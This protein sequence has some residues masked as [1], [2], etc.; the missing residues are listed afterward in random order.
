MPEETK[1]LDANGDSGTIAPLLD[2]N[3]KQDESNT[4]TQTKIKIVRRKQK[5]ANDVVASDDAKS[6]TTLSTK[7]P[8]VPETN[9]EDTII[10]DKDDTEEP[11]RGKQGKRID[12]MYMTNRKRF[13]QKMSELFKQYKE[14]HHD[15]KT[16]ISC[17]P[18]E[19]DGLFAHQELILEY[20]SSNT[21]YRGLLLYH[22]LGSGKTCASIAVAESMKHD[23]SNIIV[24]TPASLS[25]NYLAEIKKCGDPLYKKLQY[26]RFEKTTT[27]EG[28]NHLAKLLSIPVAD[29]TKQGGAW[30]AE[31][32]TRKSNFAD[33][34]VT[35]QKQI[36]QQLDKMIKS[37]Y[38]IYHY[39]GDSIREYNKLTQHGKHNP[40]NNAV[41]IIDEAH[42]FVRR[43]VNKLINKSTK[44]GTKV[45]TISTNLYEL[46]LDA[47]NVRI[48]LLSGTPI[49][50]YPHESGVLFNII[51]GHTKQWVFTLNCEYFT[52][53]DIKVD[54]DFFLDLFVKNNLKTFDYVSYSGNIL[55]V[56]K[57]PYGFVNKY[58][59]QYTKKDGPNANEPREEG[60]K[61]IIKVKATRKQTDKGKK[62][63]KRTTKKQGGSNEFKRYQGVVYDDSGEMSNADFEK[64]IRAIFDRNHIRILHTN[65]T[66]EKCLPDDM[67]EFNQKFL[68]EGQ[69]EI[70]NKAIFQKRILG[71]TSYFRSAQEELLPS[72]ELSENGLH[73]HIVNCDMSP[74]QFAE[75][76]KIREQEFQNETNRKKV[77][78]LKSKQDEVFNIPSSYRTFSRAACNFI[79]PSE[80]KRPY[81]EN[82]RNFKLEDE[83]EGS[84]EDEEET[85]EETKTEKVA[86]TQTYQERIAEALQKL[87]DGEYLSRERIGDFSPKFANI[88]D[89]LSNSE[90]VGLHLVYSNYR[91]IEGIEILRLALLKNGFAQFK[92]QKPRGA[93]TW[94]IV[95]KA[96][97]RMKPKFVLYT[98]TESEE[99]REIIRNIYNSSWDVIP[100]SLQTELTTRYGD[101]KNKLGKVIKA[102]MIT[103]SGAEGINLKNT[104][105]VHL[106]EPYWHMERIEQVIGR[107]RRICSHQDLAPELRT[108]K[109]FFYLSAF[110]DKQQTDDKYKQI[111]L[112]DISRYDQVTPV[113]T[114]QT[115]FEL[116][117]FKQTINGKI[118]DL[119]KSTSID[120]QVYSKGTESYICYSAGKVSATNPN[121]FIS[122]PDL[123]QEEGDEM[124]KEEVKR[125]VYNVKYQGKE[126]L[127]NA[128]RTELYDID[129]YRSTNLLTK[130]GR[131]VKE[132]GDYKIYL[133]T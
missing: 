10:E 60:V 103:A 131:I 15:D 129:I 53:K 100:S 128:E 81:P 52:E 40:F 50:N 47:V 42:N 68:D 88:L 20:L 117:K 94:Q 33:L 121:N 101:E 127:T 55:T 39:N 124:Q 27:Q 111:R 3:E 38:L 78:A 58:T 66:N 89:N 86:E 77:K 56:T 34:T 106:V 11:L 102:L 120:C 62:G 114:D 29:V 123:D 67:E 82:E 76:D 26:W 22:G 79:F 2:I 83:A 113:T 132:N 87:N 91:E 49:I 63:G 73:Y 12:P 72:F 23:S 126:Y 97:D 133:G 96:E 5:V 92:I 57:N 19:Q 115:L 85:D 31:T 6:K 69:G 59:R 30:I 54:R 43:I 46:L 93:K 1:F 25:Q 9:D 36:D 71:L 118:L 110:S 98:G 8:E 125:T 64:Q 18:S 70:V 28:I 65:T 130:V 107:A 95:E 75:Y 61:K 80:I 119:I 116:S 13:V 105:Y 21:P 104:R 14:R 16:T 84:S 51:K 45:E 48:V 109:V 112:R 41:V 35:Q 90:H 4:T 24:M 7:L 74:F 37:K 108:V 32:T 17:N 122:N 99:E 44:K